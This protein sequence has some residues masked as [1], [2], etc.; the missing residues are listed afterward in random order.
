M[1]EY[2]PPEDFTQI[3]TNWNTNDSMPQE[4]SSS[5]ITQPMHAMKSKAKPA[6]L[7]CG[8]DSGLSVVPGRSSIKR[9][10]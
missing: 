1:H 2:I 6:S 10:P 4:A 3:I 5:I 7:L 8:N 9:N